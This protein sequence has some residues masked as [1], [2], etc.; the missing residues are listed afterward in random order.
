MIVGGRI[1]KV[2]VQGKQLAVNSVIN[3]DNI[4]RAA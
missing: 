4:K 2:L 1:G 3:G